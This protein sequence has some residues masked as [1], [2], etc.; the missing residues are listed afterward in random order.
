M[1]VF[2]GEGAPCAA[3]SFCRKARLDEF[4]LRCRYNNID[5][6]YDFCDVHTGYWKTASPISA[7]D[8]QSYTGCDFFA[9]RSRNRYEAGVVDYRMRVSAYGVF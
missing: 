4:G 6:L 9:T 3:P 2:G 5:R 8:S 1:R 7:V